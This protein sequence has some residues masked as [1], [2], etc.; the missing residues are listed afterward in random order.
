MGMKLTLLG[1]G[2][3]NPSLERA[4]S[5]HLLE[6]GNDLVLLDCGPGSYVRFLQTGKS[7]TDITHII[8][9]HFHYDHCADLASFALARWDQSAG[10]YPEIKISGPSHVQA[11]VAS[12]FSPEG[13]FGPDQKARTEHPA[14]LGYF[15]ARGGQGARTPFSPE[16]REL[17]PGDQIHEA[18]GGW[19]FECVE[20]P[21]VQ[22]YLSNL[23]FR[24]DDGT[25]SFCYSGD[26]SYSEDFISL[27]RDCDLLLH[28]C[29]RISGTELT[30]AGQTSSA[31]HLDA[32]RTAQAMRAATCVTTHISEQMDV[33]GIAEKL[34]REMAGIYDGNIIWGKDLMTLPVTP[35]QPT[36]LI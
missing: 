27:G 3:P 34:M 12:L 20:V 32:A 29:H 16:V 5:S 2:T 13:A 9:S 22:P 14:S 11:L 35:P 8:F 19:R 4:G 26:T 24:F 33:P 15:H 6:I 21:H 18:D 23:A 36:Q 17:S 1:T 30:K 7:L 28:M 31:G 10:R 25:N